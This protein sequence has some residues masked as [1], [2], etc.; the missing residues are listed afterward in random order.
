MKENQ[1]KKE[2]LN[3]LI[4]S[5]INNNE[6]KRQISGESLQSK[7]SQGSS[8]E[9]SSS[10]NFGSSSEE[11]QEG[12]EIKESEAK[13]ILIDIF[14]NHID[15]S[16]VNQEQLNLINILFN[17]DDQTLINFVKGAAFKYETQNN[18]L[19]NLFR[20]NMNY[21]GWKLQINKSGFL[22]F[23]LTTFE[24][25]EYLTRV[26]QKNLKLNY[27]V[28]HNDFNRDKY[29]GD[30]FFFLLKDYL[31][32]NFESQNYQNDQLK[33]FIQLQQYINMKNNINNNPGVKY[34]N[35]HFS[36][37]LNYFI[38]GQIWP[39]NNNCTNFGFNA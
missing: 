23:R 19:F 27:L 20:K 28:I 5:N 21:K 35:N 12:D 6:F 33:P 22:E 9:N 36:N 18:D 31:E 3:N 2:A 11:E 14:N 34:N 4:P 1:L 16:E 25:F 38:N 15:K 13:Q 26:I 7:I 32:K 10:N 39:E 8:E 30:A 17:T 37:D 24:M 29:E